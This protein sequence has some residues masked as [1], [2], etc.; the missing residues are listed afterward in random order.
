MRT[1]VVTTAVCAAGGMALAAAAVWVA[2]TPAQ[3]DFASECASP[4]QIVNGGSTP[5]TLVPGNVVLIQAPGVFTGGVNAW[6]AGST[7]CVQAGATFNPSFVAASTGRFLNQGTATLPPLVA[8]APASVEN[9]GTLI[10]NG[11][12]INGSVALSMTVLNL[13]TGTITLNGSINIPNGVTITNEGSISATGDVN[14]NAG[15]VLN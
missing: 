9:G 3:A 13:P 11:P 6:P 2:M 14:F 10:L 8:S 4:T 1:R 12:N 15:S 7:I 5:L